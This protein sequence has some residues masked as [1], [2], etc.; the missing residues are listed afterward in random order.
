MQKYAILH[1]WTWRWTSRLLCNCQSTLTTNSNSNDSPWNSNVLLIFHNKVLKDVLCK[2][3]TLNL[4]YTLLALFVQLPH[5][6]CSAPL[7]VDDGLAT[8][9]HILCCMEFSITLQA[10]LEGPAFSQE[11]YLTI[12][13]L[14]DWQ[15][16][17]A[18]KMHQLWFLV[19]S[20]SPQIQEHYTGNF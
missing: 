15:D 14:S 19:W 16:P 1:L 2:L 10:V 18:W 7:L 13:L 3:K 11:I 9:M 12:Y 5:T 17:Q 4:I 6:C 20:K 8:A